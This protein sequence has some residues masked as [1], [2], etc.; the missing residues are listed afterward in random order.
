ML[1]QPK[2][3]FTQ[4]DYHFYFL[5]FRG[6]IAFVVLANTSA[7]V[8]RVHKLCLQGHFFLLC[9]LIYHAPNSTLSSLLNKK[10]YLGTTLLMTTY[11]E[12]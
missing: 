1:K 7:G 6:F 11:L 12:V 10:A 9:S 3:L 2:V 5:K 4:L 8:E